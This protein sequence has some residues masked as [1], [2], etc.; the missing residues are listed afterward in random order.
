[1]FGNLK[2][3]RRSLLARGPSPIG[4]LAIVL[5]LAAAMRPATLVAGIAVPG[6]LQVHSNSAQ[7]G[8]FDTTGLA[9]LISE[10]GNGEWPDTTVIVIKA[11][12][13]FVFN[14]TQMVN[15]EITAGDID[16]GAGA[17]VAFAV[18]P[19]AT[20]IE[21]PVNVASTMASTIRFND[22]QLRATSCAT[23][24]VGNAADILVD[25]TMPDGTPDDEVLVDVS[26]INNEEDLDHF[27]LTADPL[28]QDPNQNILV[29]ITAEDA[30]DNPINNFDLG[31]LA[32]PTPI[33]L[34]AANGAGVRTFS[35][36]SLT[37]TP[38]V[39]NQAEIDDMN[40][41]DAN[42]QGTFNVTSPL[43]ED[44]LINISA[45]LGPAT[46]SV[47]VRWITANCNIAP[48]GVLKPVNTLHAVTATVLQNGVTPVAGV[49]VAFNI[50]AGPNAGVMGTDTTNGAGQAI[51]FYVGG[52]NTGVD[53]IEG[54]GEIGGM[55]AFSS[56]ATRRS[57]GSIPPAQWPHSPPPLSAECKPSTSMSIAP[58]ASTHRTAPWFTLKSSPAPMSASWRTSP[59]PQ[60][61]PASCTQAAAAPASIRFAPTAPSPARL[62][63]ASSPRNGSTPPA[64]S[65][66]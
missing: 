22:I 16:L 8:T 21:F 18:M 14:T 62:S 52:P 26:V 20:T 17:G 13:G 6:T 45:T 55:A 48:T 33:T 39:A 46:G 10:S 44:P 9:P 1:M 41:F 47:N 66:R 58:P 49:D 60:A 35:S 24:I 2:R 38:T 43:G 29:T 31:M 64:R 36:G 32:P 30:C 5:A 37:V 40:V 15:A 23:A 53:T 7:D 19:S 51:F 25:I 59:P 27:R 11:P 3:V 42:G 34:V 54:T 56:P 4:S 28:T 63:S 57:S 65:P 50:T 61:R 12:T